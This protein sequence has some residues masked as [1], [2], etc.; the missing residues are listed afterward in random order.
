MTTNGIALH[1][2]LDSMVDAGLTGINISLDTLDPF[3]FQLMTRRNGLDAVIRSIERVLEMNKLGANIKL[4]INCVVMRGRN[5]GEILRFVELGREKDVE[6]R[7]I[8]YMP[9]DGNKWSQGKM[10]GYLEMLD[11]IRH[12]YPSITKVQDHRQDTS[13]TYQI[14]GF[15]G[16]VGFVT[17]MTHHFCGSCNRLRI[18]SDGSLKVCLFGNSEVSL[19]DL[20]RKNRDGAPMDQ[21]L[22]EAM[23]Q[24]Q[25]LQGE[26]ELM[27]VIGMAV[28]RKKA[29][30]AG[31]K[32]LASMKNRPMV[33]IGG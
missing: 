3:Q 14:P 16:R 2:K 8:E 33:L 17:S 31:M 28:Q 12:K 25:F 27:E 32:E 11:I 13:K 5:E 6:V 30:H 24:G 15:T 7:F 4:K 26:Q 20:L 29:Q 21:D 19:R 1:R 10:L 18:T 9:F 22:S 23:S